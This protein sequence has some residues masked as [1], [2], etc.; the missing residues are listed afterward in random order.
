MSLSCFLKADN[1][2]SCDVLRYG[3]TGMT[4]KRNQRGTTQPAKG[5][6]GGSF[7]KRRRPD[8][9]SQER[10]GGRQYGKTGR[11]QSTELRPCWLWPHRPI[12]RGAMSAQLAPMK[13]FFASLQPTNDARLMMLAIY[14]S[15]I[16]YAQYLLPL[17]AL[18]LPLK[19]G[20]F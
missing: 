2:S 6:G 11:S 4:G 15:I 9:C 14:V 20:H 13:A 18:A 12:S 19:P 3:M 16:D 7:K 1:S 17:Q 5:G 8:D 10:E